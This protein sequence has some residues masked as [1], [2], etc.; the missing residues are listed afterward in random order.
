MRK[1]RSF[2][3]RLAN[4]SNQGDSRQ[5][6]SDDKIAERYVCECNPGAKPADSGVRGLFR[7]IGGLAGYG[8]RL[9]HVTRLFGGE[10]L[11]SASGPGEPTVELSTP[12][13]INGLEP[14][15]L[16]T[17]A[18]PAD[19]RH[20]PSTPTVRASP[21]QSM[22]RTDADGTDANRIFQSAPEKKRWSVAL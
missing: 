8:K 4:G 21:L 16:R 6:F 10:L 18:D 2:P 9:F 12:K 5:S 14:L 17:V 20:G 3:N 11:Q 22:D 1:Y 13:P 19:G 7:G 15:I